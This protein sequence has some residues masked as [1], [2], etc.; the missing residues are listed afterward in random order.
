MHLFAH[1]SWASTKAFEW[2][3][4]ESPMHQLCA[5]LLL[6]RLF[7][8]GLSPSE[9]DAQEYLDQTETALRSPDRLTARAALKALYKYMDL[10]ADQQN[11]AE[12]LLQKLQL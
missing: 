6:A 11:A 10:G 1:T 3:A 5:Y 7:M 12:H 2:M 8:Q 4:Q 9:R